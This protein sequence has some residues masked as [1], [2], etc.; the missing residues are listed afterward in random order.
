MMER[1][2]DRQEKVEDKEL[3]SICRERK[4]VEPK[5]I[6]VLYWKVEGKGEGLVNESAGG[7]LHSSKIL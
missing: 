5:K 3:Y 1:N 4:N 7:E 6:K 2:N